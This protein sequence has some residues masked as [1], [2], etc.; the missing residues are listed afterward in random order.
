MRPE[1][2]FTRDTSSIA[3][4]RAARHEV[5]DAVRR[6]GGTRALLVTDP[7]P[8]DGFDVVDVLASLRAAGIDATVRNNVE[9]EP[10]DADCERAIA[11]AQDAGFNA[12]VAV[13]G[14]SVIGTAKTANLYA[15]YPADLMAYVNP[16]IG[17]GEPVPGPLRLLVAVPTTAGTGSETTGAAGWVVGRVR[18]CGPPHT[19]SRQMAQ[20]GCDHANHRFCRARS[21]GR[22]HEPQPRSGGARATGLRPAT[23]GGGSAS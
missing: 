23:R 17:R 22:R 8:R 13:G 1:S 7:G 3:C 21:D 14:S 12:Y 19:S 2:I 5:G 18:A 15:T 20:I 9:I 6:L 11:S 16:P 10:S 4:G